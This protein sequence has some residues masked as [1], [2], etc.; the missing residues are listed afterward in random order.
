[1]SLRFSLKLL[2]ALVALCVLA[3][4][5]VAFIGLGIDAQ[6]WRE[7]VAAALSRALGREVRLD[8]PARLTL[9][10]RPDIRVGDI[11][12]ANP[13]GFD[14]PEFGRIGELRLSMEL[15]PLL[16]GEVRVRELY[17][18]DVAIRLVR[19]NDGRG[20]WVLG[21]RAL[22][23]AAR[24]PADLPRLDVHRVA[25]E[26]ILIDYVGADAT[27]R[28]ELTELTGEARP[29]QALR[30]AARG[31]VDKLPYTADATAAP[32]PALGEGE[33]WP[34]DITLRFPGTV[35]NASGTLSGSLHDPALRVAF[36]AGTADAR[37]VE[38]LLGVRLPPVGAAAVA[39]DLDVASG[40]A[41]LRSINGVAGAT[42]VSGDL[43]LD[44]SGPRPKLT[45]RLASAALDL[46]SFHAP[47]SAPA[48][49]SAP[50]DPSAEVETLADAFEELERSD[51]DLKRLALLDADVQLSVAHWAGVPGD[52][53]DL[54]TRLRIEAGKL[55][56]PLAVTI[57]GARFEG[58]VAA[59]GTTA[60]PRLRASLVAR[61]APIGGL[62]ELVFDAPYV[63]GSVRRFEVALDAAGDRPG[64]LARDL[65][66]RIRVE[67]ARFT[68]GN[69]AGGRPVAM[70][71]DAA[72]VAQP[73]GRTIAG[74]LRGSLRGKPFDGTFRAGTVE[75]ILRDQ[76]TP[77]GFDGTS[78]SVRARLSGTLAEP[79]GTA[80]PQVA[81]DVTAPRA[82]E[83][84]PWLG[85]S[86][87]SDARVALKG[88]V[89]VRQH[90]ASLTGGSL[91]VG[92]TAI[93]GAL[94]WRWVG[95]KPLVQA[96]LVAELLA[97]AELRAL[98]PPP[99]AAR[100]ATLLE[101]PILP[102]SLDFADSDVELRVK[103][104][105]GLRLE[106]TDVVFQGRMRGGEITPSPFSLRA[107]GNALTGALAL[108]ARG[109]APT[110][111]LWVA[112]DDFDVG[113]LLRRLRVA[114]DIESRIGTLRLYADIRE[115]RLGDV[116]EQ[117]S[118][119]AS[120]ESGTLDFRDANS[121]ARLR[122]AVD[123]G[124]VR[125]DAG[126][127]VTASL[128]GTTG[129]VP[130]TLKAQTARLR[131]FVE[132]DKR[133][134]FTLTAETPAAKLAISGTAAPQRDP[135]VALSLALTG[136]RLNGLD[137]LLE[138]S[139]PPWGPYAL[140]ARLRF[141]RRG[142]EVDAMRLAV[143]T[144]V[145][146]GRGW[147]DTSRTPPKF[148]VALAA[149]RIQLDDFPFGH[150][151]P[152]EVPGGPATPLTVERARS[153]VAEGAR[154][155]H[156]IFGRELL[157]R[158]D[159]TFDL[160][161]KRVVSGA[162]E[163]GRGRLRAE[164]ANGRA[165]IGP[166]EV[167]GRAGAARGSLVYEPRERDVVVAARVKVDHFDYGLLAQTLRPGANLDGAL[168]LDFRLDATA[169]RL[170]AA[171]ATGSGRFDFAVWPKELTGGVFDFWT[172][173]LLFRL[174]PIVDTSASPMNCLVGHFDLER[175]KLQSV[176]L[177]IDTVNTRTEGGGSGR[178]R[179][180]RDPP[181]VRAA[182]QGAAVLQLR[183]RRS[184]S[185]ERST[186]I[187]SACAR[188]MRSARPRD[189]WPR[190]SSCRSSASSASA[191]RAT[192]ATCARTR[193]DRS[194]RGSH[195]V[196]LVRRKRDPAA[197]MPSLVVGGLPSSVD[198]NCGDAASL[199][200]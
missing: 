197:G 18:R 158:G 17:G 89:Q 161:A 68:Y 154:Q 97:P 41:A 35:L 39:G 117:S 84:T 73:R 178:S 133:L 182:P 150:W 128:T 100:R 63:A 102:E 70:Q 180:R 95:A 57:G 129:A 42:A 104:V 136:D 134:P 75:R 34:F 59:D 88:T 127:P 87:A 72:E 163:L 190:R 28:V 195:A 4:A 106:L 137:S 144:S 12:I 96:S 54:T 120:I 186:T 46:R 135:D 36:G 184:R 103:R 11:R 130:I 13:P 69:Y 82:R 62:A 198:Y 45:G 99:G 111:S 167:E 124:E 108:D 51:L 199:R 157:G 131:E 65:A 56:A 147:L 16:R 170:T 174:L 29:G 8:G 80:G 187:A 98:R 40:T 175:G 132:T 162:G 159:G 189:G 119:V 114:R 138:T 14:S 91:L 81:F 78:G 1:M 141:P 110:A 90:E 194:A 191:Y 74:K 86:S 64:E 200:S 168:S 177:V 153:T 176:R 179:D 172:V 196:S 115:R 171:L 20:N 67:G 143:G 105:D 109:D 149:E 192:G 47:A 156:A 38:R 139:L 53:S 44:T 118:F 24:E 79:T 26:N 126:A 193:G 25:L 122:I 9:S 146:E 66:G 48:G 19:S 49:A 15:L 123:A 148:D 37:E 183:D 94:T 112:G 21:A 113:P 10:F 151:S 23:A 93:A 173:N 145:V 85:F 27:R 5:A 166:I 164:V 71:L 31:A 43:S 125:A 55:A 107:E 152:F 188:P 160:A 169:P 7:P 76:R 185:A 83:L 22:E 92:R 30:L 32:L 77:F 3:L 61:D 116:L 2:A 155:V 60:P 165:T 50:A 142:Y 6:R 33:P 121:R 101:I 52:V 181:P 58:E 140:T